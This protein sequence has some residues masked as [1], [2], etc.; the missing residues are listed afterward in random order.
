MLLKLGGISERVLGGL[1]CVPGSSVGKAE[2]QSTKTEL[3]SPL[4]S[5]IGIMTLQSEICTMRTFSIFV[6]PQFA[7]TTFRTSRFL[8]LG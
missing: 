2:Y 7:C 5:L 6:A 3:E 4:T 1:S 8:L